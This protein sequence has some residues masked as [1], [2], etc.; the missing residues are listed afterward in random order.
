M[1]VFVVLDTNVIVVSMLTRH[2]DSAT[3]RIINAITDLN[4][5]ER[6]DSNT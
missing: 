1:K 5:S 6:N 4:H 2:N 3:K